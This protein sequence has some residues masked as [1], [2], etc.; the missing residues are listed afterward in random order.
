MSGSTFNNTAQVGGDSQEGSVTDE[1]PT[2]NTGSGST[3]AAEVTASKALIASTESWTSDIAPLQAAIGEILT[4]QATFDLPEGLTQAHP[5]L[6]IIVDTLPAGMAYVADSARVYAVANTATSIAWGS[7][8]NVTNDSVN[9]A[10]ITPAFDPATGRL[11]FNFGDI[12]NNDTDADTERLVLTYQ[13]QVLN[14]EGN[15]R[16]DTKTNSASLNYKKTA[17]APARATRRQPMSPSSSPIRKSPRFPR[18]PL[19]P[20]L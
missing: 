9:P 18:P 8:G 13:V 10:S 17:L 12:R 1:R 7:F 16:A 6:P 19:R 3:E 20:P 11:D 14:T 5:T 4:Y 15:N 2:G